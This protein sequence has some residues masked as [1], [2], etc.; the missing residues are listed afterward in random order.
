VGRAAADLNGTLAR[1]DVELAD[2]AVAAEEVFPREVIDVP[3]SA[4][5]SQVGMRRAVM[6]GAGGIK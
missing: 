4:I 6:T 1:L 5:E 2:Q 3:L